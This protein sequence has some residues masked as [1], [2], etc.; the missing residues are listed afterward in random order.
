MGEKPTAA[1]S[2]LALSD[3]LFEEGRL[4]ESEQFARSALPDLPLANV[5]LC[6]IAIGRKDVAAA[7]RYLRDLKSDD[8]ALVALL[9][10]KLALAS[11]KPSVAITQLTQLE[12]KLSTKIAVPMQFEVRLA[13]IEAKLTAKQDAKSE[14]E[15][16]EWDATQK[17]FGLI[18]R[19]AAALKAAT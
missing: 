15:S 7:S 17:G 9:N 8:D 13:L 11:G 14:I 16:L 19:K 12:K 1:E 2:M 18:A 4:P 6:R 10:A 3:V 5:M